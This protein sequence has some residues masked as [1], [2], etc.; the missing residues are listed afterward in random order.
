MSTAIY[1]SSGNIGI[2]F[3]IPINIAKHAYKQLIESG[4]VE[5]GFLGVGIQ[6]LTPEFA[7]VFGLK[8][9]TKGVL[10]PEVTKDSAADKAGLKHHDVILELD[11]EPVESASAL[12]K[13]IS[14]LK[15][16]SRVELVVWRDGRR[17]TLTVKLGKRPSS[18]EPTGTLPTDIVE[19]LGFTVETLTDELAERYGYEDQAG[20]IVTSLD[21]SSEAAQRGIMPGMLIKEVNRQQVRNRKEFN[22]A[23]KKARKKGVA[24]LLVR[25]EYTRFILLPLSEK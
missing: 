14:M 6:N 8:N 19:E 13:R 21:R 16:G 18:E 23:I 24:L 9:T 4:T 11:G 10:I 1:G 3:A 22:E 15:P 12:Q 20:V 25:Q 7:E 2:G 5:R 17:K